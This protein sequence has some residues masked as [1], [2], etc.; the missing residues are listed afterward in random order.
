MSGGVGGGGRKA[1]PYPDSPLV[2]RMVITRSFLVHGV[3]RVCATAGA[4]R[5]GSAAARGSVS[6]RRAAT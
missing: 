1:D 2:P 4:K 3:T 5:W 6:S